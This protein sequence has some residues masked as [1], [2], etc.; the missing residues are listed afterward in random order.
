MRRTV[1][2]LSSVNAPATLRD[3]DGDDALTSQ[4]GTADT[5][6]GGAGNDTM[7]GGKWGGLVHRRRRDRRGRLHRSPRRR[8]VTV[9]VGN[10]AADDGSA[11][12]GP[13]GARDSVK[14]DVEDVLGSGEDDTLTAAAGG[15]R[16]HGSAGDDTL[17]GGAGADSLF[18]DGGDD[19]LNGKG[20]NDS[21]TGGAGDDVL[22]GGAGADDL[23]GDDEFGSDGHDTV[24]YASRTAD[25]PVS[26]TKDRLANDGGAIDA[27][28]AR[29]DDVA[30]DVEVLIGGA[31]GDT[32]DGGAA[33]ALLVGGAGGD[34][35]RNGTATYAD[36]P[37]R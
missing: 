28:G 27:S 2:V 21:L 17:N 19:V 1:F 10:G 11:A 9:T 20:G 5:L 4:V 36:P 18:G 32:L 26:V 12:D 22:D 34:T 29:K 37:R 31:A 8:R 6:E 14:A 13:A 23:T 24:T 16:L 35:L 25:Q 15:S 33:K 7:S 3:G 30:D